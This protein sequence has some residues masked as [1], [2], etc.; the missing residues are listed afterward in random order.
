MIAVTSEV[1]KEQDSTGM[2]D[3]AGSEAGSTKGKD[4]F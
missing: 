2:L 4:V 3:G 1:A